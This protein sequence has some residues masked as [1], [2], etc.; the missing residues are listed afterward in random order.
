M[1][2]PKPTDEVEE[3]KELD[4]KKTRNIESSESSLSRSS[5]RPHYET[6]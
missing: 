1:A 3:E 2:D 6:L 4:I 5:K